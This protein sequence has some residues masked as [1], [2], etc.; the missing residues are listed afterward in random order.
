MLIEFQVKSVVL[1]T[2]NRARFSVAVE[3]FLKTGTLGYVLSHSP[4]LL[5]LSLSHWDSP[6]LAVYLFCSFILA[7]VVSLSVS[8]VC[9]K[10]HVFFQ[11]R[12]RH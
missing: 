9:L 6:S 5:T 12:S 4:S 7:S 11:V 2:L 10:L 1:N 8:V 3:S